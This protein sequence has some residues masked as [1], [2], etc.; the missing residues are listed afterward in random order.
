M[1]L[2]T[3]AQ[4]E[5]L[6]SAANQMERRVGTEGEFCRVPLTGRANSGRGMSL[7]SVQGLSEHL[8]EMGNL[9]SAIKIND[10]ELQNLPK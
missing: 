7:W 8:P 2:G 4:G 9:R 3:I 6:D 5:S 10:K 1:D